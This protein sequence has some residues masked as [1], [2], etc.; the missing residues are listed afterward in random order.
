MTAPTGTAQTRP[1]RTLV[2]GAG[3]VGSFL[4]ALLG[5]VGHD[6]TLIRIFESD[7]ERPLT[8]VA[9][10]N[11]ADSSD[12]GHKGEDRAHGGSLRRRPPMATRRTTGADPKESH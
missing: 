8:L 11:E 3:A 9:H 4:G 5:S 1:H 7:S 6:V 2:V 10:I 12:K